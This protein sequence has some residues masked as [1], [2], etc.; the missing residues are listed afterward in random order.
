MVVN[1]KG[2]VG[3]SMIAYTLIT[4]FGYKGYEIDPYGS[5]ARRVGEDKVVFVD[6]NGKLPDDI[7]RYKKV[8]FDFGGFDDALIYEAAKVS[9]MV[10][11]PF[12]PTLESVQTTMDMFE[13]LKEIGLPVLFVANKAAKE[14]DVNSIIDTF[15]EELGY[16]V[17]FYVIPYLIGIQTSINNKESILQMA[18]KKGFAGMPYRKA[19]QVMSGLYQEILNFGVRYGI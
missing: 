14:I 11:V 8:V 17:D 2:G 7:E 9:D 1:F 16:E 18:N 5:L 3:K 10:I 15:N 6:I 13:S 19:A 4:S 12:D